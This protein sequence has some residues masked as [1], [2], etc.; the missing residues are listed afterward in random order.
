MLK[1]LIAT[2]TVET[3][4]VF[5]TCFKIL[6]PLSKR[7]KKSE[8][9][10]TLLREMLQSGTSSQQRW[11]LSMIYFSDKDNVNLANPDTKPLK[12]LKL[13]KLFSPDDLAELSL[14]RSEDKDIDDNRH[15][16][17]IA[18]FYAE[19]SQ[20]KELKKK[21]NNRMGDYCISQ[22]KPDDP[23]NLAIAQMN[24]NWLREA[25]FCFKKAD[26]NKKLNKTSG[27]YE[28]NKLKVQFPLFT[29]S[30]TREE[31]NAQ[32]DTINKIATDIVNGGTNAIIDT[33]LGL[34]I[35]IFGKTA[36][37]LLNDAKKSKQEFFYTQ[38]F[39]NAI[40]D[41]YGNIKE[42]SF[43]QWHIYQ[44]IDTVYRNF[45]Y[46]IF[47][48]V[49]MNGL[50]QS[51]LTYDILSKYLLDM[52]FGLKIEKNYN[53]EVYGSTYLDRVDIGLKEFLHQNELMMNN[54]PTDWR[55]CT[56][57]LTTQ[58][59]GLLRDIVYRL[60][61]SISK[62]KHDSDT[63]LILLEGLLNDDCLKQAFD[64]DDLLLFRETFTNAGYNIRNNIAHGMYL[65]QEYTST[66]A[67]LVFISVLRLT[68]ATYFIDK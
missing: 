35:N 45:T 22:I 66:R 44:L 50:K 57:F 53:S 9:L 46:H 48:L 29:H 10:G 42:V 54:Q 61:G 6:Y 60:G 64:A 17:E 1:E 23:H 67:L 58:F 27:L 18:Q 3:N 40:V 13:G 21:A 49:V 14:V 4:Y 68:K 55:F 63:E 33:L 38:F 11:I 12:P 24:D 51:S 32:I 28:A 2:D 19:K 43:E 5:C 7:I 34:T 20:S 65:P 62:P 47:S 41:S 31:R 25:M 59:E 52:G 36:E 26:A 30:I 16:L 56:I 8:E 15:L 37:K 39:R